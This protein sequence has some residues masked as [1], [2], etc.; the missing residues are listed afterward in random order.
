MIHQNRSR[1]RPS[2]IISLSGNLEN[3]G[4]DKN[5]KNYLELNRMIE[6]KIPNER[7]C[8]VVGK[9]WFPE[10]LWVLL[11]NITLPLY[12]ALKT[13]VNKNGVVKKGK[14]QKF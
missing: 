1:G 12:V 10:I 9:E 11:A 2:K 14:P 4:L 6:Q 3:L 8:L 7:T 13:L 5:L